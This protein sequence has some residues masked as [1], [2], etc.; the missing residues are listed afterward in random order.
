M[1]NHRRRMQ[2]RRRRIGFDVPYS[3][4]PDVHNEGV[5]LRKRLKGLNRSFTGIRRAL[6]PLRAA[7]L[8]LG[9]AAGSAALVVDSFNSALEEADR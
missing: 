3:N 6:W 7:F 9:A 5:Q 1:T 4:W 2:T 8:Q